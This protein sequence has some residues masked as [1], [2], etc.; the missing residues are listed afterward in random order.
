MKSFKQFLINE[1]IIR[2]SFETEAIIVLRK[3][4]DMVDDGH[5]DYSD[6]KISMNIGRLIHD[7]K[8]GNLDLM[9]IKSGQEGVQVGRH[10]VEE[11]HAIFILT[12]AIPARDKIDDFLIQKERT[13][14]FKKV[15]VKFINDA[16]LDIT[17]D[18]EGTRVE[19]STSLN[20]REQFEDLYKNIVS[21]LDNVFSKYL[22]AKRDIYARMNKASSDMG[23]TEIL[24]ASAIRLRKDMLG[25]TLGD[26][27]NKAIQIMGPEKYKMLNRE[28]REK[29]DARLESFYETKIR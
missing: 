23:E 20:T 5:V 10:S 26:F 15:F 16:D 19:Q 3:I 17:A 24:K 1:A 28:Y 4:I 6:N 14:T 22:Q 13:G 2:Q 12:K 21:E 18:H 9:I 27:K 7:R 25:A 29:L 8:Y 11:K